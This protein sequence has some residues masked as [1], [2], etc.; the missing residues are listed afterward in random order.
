[1]KRPPRD[2]VPRFFEKFEKDSSRAAFEEGVQ[3]FKNQLIQR[4]VVKKQEQEA[5][6]K[7]AQE[8]A[9]AEGQEELQPVSLVEAM[10][11]MSKEERMGPG[12]LDPVEVFAALPE[13]LQEC[14]KSG[15]VEKLKEAAKS[16]PPGEFEGHFQKCIDAGLWSQS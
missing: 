14:F 2:L 7:A 16:M 10:H 12:G 3:H 11:S 9:A 8:A 4:A 15:D 5:E 1:M 6:E 13:E